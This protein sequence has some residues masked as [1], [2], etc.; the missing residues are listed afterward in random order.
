MSEKRKSYK[1]RRGNRVF[2]VFDWRHPKTGAQRWR[3]AWRRGVGEKWR[4]KTVRTRAEAEE[5]IDRITE[6][7]DQGGLVFSS[8]PERRRR[9]LESIH[10]EIRE[11]D[12][13]AI[14]EMIRARR[15]SAEIAES[16]AR[17]LEWKIEKA[18]EETRHI[19]NVRRNVEGMAEH[20]K[21]R[22]VVDVGAEELKG[23]WEKRVEGLAK[24]TRNDVRGNLVE[25]WNWAIWDGIFPK[26]V[27]PADKLPSAA[28]DDGEKRVL[29]AD[30]LR[31]LLA[32]VDVRWR[33]WVVLG[34]FC[35]LRP[36]EI[37]PQTREGMAKAG[38][39]GIRREEIDFRFKVI[40]LPA[41]VSKVD[42][43][44]KVPLCDAAIAWLAWAGI[45][46][47]QTGPVCLLN[48]AEKVRGEGPVTETQR[49]GK[50]VFGDG[51]P[52]DALRHSYGS[53][54]NA[55]VRN[56][57]MVA[58]EMGTSERMLRRH[59][60]NPRKTE[61]GEEWFSIMPGVPICSDEKGVGLVDSNSGVV[62]KPLKSKAG[63]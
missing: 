10:N 24:K 33:A 18:G 60:H 11:D 63:R 31:S 5:A 42:T 36:E 27:T 3:F 29:T 28:V 13:A 46:D 16:A 48:P 47:G 17:F 30:E 37:A 62:T 21:G 39:R 12:E 57:A 40:H 44:R 58:E 49:L 51:W 34:A 55:I 23:W 8:L 1:T 35:G 41:C 32:A 20:F 14:M 7:M 45:Q 59:Y 26:D 6:E 61:E 15:K 53:Y 56:L 38:K 4:Y 19:V 50:L 2:T 22:M 54:R 9:F 43:A 52:K 25:F